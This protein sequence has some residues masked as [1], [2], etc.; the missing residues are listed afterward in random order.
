M[1]SFLMGDYGNTVSTELCYQF[2]FKTENTTSNEEEESSNED[3]SIY[4]LTV[5]AVYSANSLNLIGFSVDDEVIP[6]TFH[7]LG[8][9]QELSKKAF[10]TAHHYQSSYLEGYHQA[11]SLDRFLLFESFL[12]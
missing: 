8:L 12:I 11:H 6:T 5:H 2:D 1:F 9:L 10:L 4:Q 7:T 3:N